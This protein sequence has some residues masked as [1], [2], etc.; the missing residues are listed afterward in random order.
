VTALKKATAAA[1]NEA[2]MTAV[3]ITTQKA[4]RCAIRCLIAE[5]GFRTTARHLLLR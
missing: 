2:V 5:G 3:R 1:M 4:T